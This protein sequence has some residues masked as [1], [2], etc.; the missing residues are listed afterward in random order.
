MSEYSK[1]LCD[2]RHKE[3]NRVSKAIFNKLEDLRA[4]QTKIE[5]ALF[6]D[7]GKPSHQSRLNNMEGWIKRFNTSILCLAVPVLINL[8]RQ[9]ISVFVK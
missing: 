3:A 9:V 6:R 7:N 8:I 2:E 1:E 4:T 5:D